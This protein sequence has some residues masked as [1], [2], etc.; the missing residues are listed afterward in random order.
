MADS[1]ISAYGRRL[2]AALT[3]RFAAAGINVER[4]NYDDRWQTWRVVAIGSRSE[5]IAAGLADDAWFPEGRKR[6]TYIHDEFGAIVSVHKIV[7][8]TY[9]VCR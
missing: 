9:K 7:R 1:E 4:L 3:R 2:C 8:H 6:V 5:L